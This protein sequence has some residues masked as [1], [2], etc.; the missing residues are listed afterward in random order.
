MDFSNVMLHLKSHR[1]AWS[2]V[3][4]SF[5]VNFAIYCNVIKKQ[6]EEL[7]ELKK[8]YSKKRDILAGKEREGSKTGNNYYHSM[9]NGAGKIHKAF[10]H[11]EDFTK[12]IKEIFEIAQKKGFSLTRVTYQIK[13]LLKEN[14]YKYFISFK[15]VGTYPRLKE[16]IYHIEKSPSFYT[17]NHISMNSGQDKKEISL[18]LLLV[19]H[20]T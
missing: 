15:I 16:F 7:E 18:S 11:R 5:I 2:V 13:P 3:L 19:V 10:L 20:L 17:L 14:I 12:V 6:T 9:A 1:F 8:E 4:L